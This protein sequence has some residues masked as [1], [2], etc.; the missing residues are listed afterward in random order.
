MTRIVLGVFLALAVAACGSDD[1]KKSSDNGG[2]GGGG[3]G[4]SSQCSCT[5]DFSCEGEAPN[6]VCRCGNEGEY[7]LTRQQAETKCKK[8]E[9]AGCTPGGGDTATYTAHPGGSGG[10]GD[11]NTDFGGGGQPGDEDMN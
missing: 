1:S 10:S 3:G 7:T 2:G 9:P 11:G 8:C 6:E 4:S 5:L